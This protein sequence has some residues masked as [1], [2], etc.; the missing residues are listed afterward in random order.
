MRV[1]VGPGFTSVTVDMEG[2][3]EIEVVSMGVEDAEDAEDAGGFE[4]VLTVELGPKVPL[5]ALL[6]KAMYPNRPLGVFPQNSV[7]KP[8]QV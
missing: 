8:P 7:S 4:V 3:A 5:G 2:G 1:L 6:I